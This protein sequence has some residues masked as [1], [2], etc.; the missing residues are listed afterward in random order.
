MLEKILEITIKYE[1]LITAMGT[2]LTFLLI[3][4][5]LLYNRK[6]IKE[7]KK[8]IKEMKKSNEILGENLKH[9]K[10]EIKNNKRNNDLEIVSNLIE[11]KII[12][13]SFLYLLEKRNFEKYIIA[14]KEE[15]KKKY[16]ENRLKSDR[17]YSILDCIIDENKKII[18]YSA[19]NKA[20]KEAF[21]F[22]YKIIEDLKLLRG[23]LVYAPHKELIGKILSKEISNYKY[24]KIIHSKKVKYKLNLHE[25]I[26]ISNIDIETKEILKEIWEYNNGFEKQVS[27]NCYYIE[28]TEERLKEL[29]NIYNDFEYFKTILNE[30]NKK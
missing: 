9:S 28:K 7:T 2:V 22:I 18:Y 16:V 27:E 11:K 14:K 15:F 20:L 26:N 10:E 6:I 8:N 13:E 24:Y 12:E 5:T 19:D 23:I 21:N 29:K 1:K 17:F 3:C 25:K 30:Y 4:I